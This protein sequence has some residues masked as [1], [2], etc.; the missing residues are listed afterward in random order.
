MLVVDEETSKSVADDLRKRGR[1][2][3]SVYRLN[4]TG[5]KDVPL[6]RELHRRLAGTDWMLITGDDAMPGEHAVVIAELKI[7][8][9]TIDGR[10]QSYAGYPT[11]DCWKRDVI[12]RWAHVMEVQPAGSVRRYGRSHQVWKQR[13]SKPG[14]ASGAT[15]RTKQVSGAQQAVVE[16]SNVNPAEVPVQLLAAPGPVQP[17]LSSGED[18]K[19]FSPK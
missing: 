9:A 1:N 10:P 6:L 7:T 4:L 15:K 8:I 13:R 14:A 11:Q 19:P 18:P 12:H 2:G 5:Y 16:A 3:S 17:E